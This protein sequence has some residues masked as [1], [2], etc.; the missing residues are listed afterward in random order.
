MFCELFTRLR[1]KIFTSVNTAKVRLLGPPKSEKHLRVIRMPN[2]PIND[3]TSTFIHI[4]LGVPL[5]F[6]EVNYASLIFG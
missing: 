6:E 4:S 1:A 2:N 5:L 3:K